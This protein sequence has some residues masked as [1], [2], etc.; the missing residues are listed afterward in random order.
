M[1]GTVLGG[2]RAANTNKTRYGDDYY[3]MIGA[4]GGKKS[5]GGGFAS[6]KIGA[7]GLTGRERAEIA[8]RKGGKISKRPVNANRMV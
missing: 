2:K 8:G 7:D 4:A 5:R 1:P 6:N 3:E